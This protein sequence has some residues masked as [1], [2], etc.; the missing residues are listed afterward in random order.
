MMATQIPITDAL[1]ESFGLNEAEI[2]Q[3]RKILDRASIVGPSTQMRT[4]ENNPA[5]MLAV[6]LMRHHDRE[7]LAWTH[8]WLMGTSP[9]RAET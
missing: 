1:L 7:T 3:F 6:T 5:E 4:I 9:T 8:R 2:G